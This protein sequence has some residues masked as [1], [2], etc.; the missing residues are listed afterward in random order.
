MC[1]QTRPLIAGFS[2]TSTIISVF[3]VHLLVCVILLG[4]HSQ[5]NILPNG[6]HCWH[7]VNESRVA[8]F[9]SVRLHTWTSVILCNLQ[10]RWLDS[11]HTSDH[12]PTHNNYRRNLTL[13]TTFLII[14]NA[15]QKQLNS[16]VV[17]Y[18]PYSYQHFES[19]GN[20]TNLELN[21]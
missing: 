1:S 4:F 7:F 15:I 9:W 3:G 16:A 5:D 11:P 6:A 14:I 8:G 2:V 13:T 20:Y 18:T 19:I 21:I 12:L 17:S 10:P